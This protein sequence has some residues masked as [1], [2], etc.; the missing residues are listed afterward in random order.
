MARLSKD[1]D[2]LAADARGLA[3]LAAIQVDATGP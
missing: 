2:A 1:W 3:A